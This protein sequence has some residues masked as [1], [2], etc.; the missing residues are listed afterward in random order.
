MSTLR[1]R[2]AR[3]RPDWQVSVAALVDV[4]ETW[5]AGAGSRD[6]NAHFAVAETVPGSDSAIV[7]LLWLGGVGERVCGSCGV[8]GRC[9]IGGRGEV[10]F[11]KSDD[12]RN[13]MTHEIR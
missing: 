12:S 7:Q 13:P 6:M 4:F 9:G 8:G 5:L 11:A 2:A 3:R 1:A 10:R